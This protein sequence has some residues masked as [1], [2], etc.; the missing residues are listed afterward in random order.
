MGD[1]PYSEALQVNEFRY[2]KY[3]EQKEVFK[4]ILDDLEQ[5]DSH[6]AKATEGISGDPFYNGDPAKWRKATNVLR[7][8]VLMALQKRADD[9]PELQ[10]KEKF[11][12]I[13]NISI[14]VR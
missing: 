12:Q 9:T 7:L 5:A 4:G 8:K 3:D 14:V 13:V 11:A 6:F 1:I 10:I 2:P